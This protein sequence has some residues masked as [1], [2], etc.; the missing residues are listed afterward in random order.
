MSI[1]KWIQFVKN[2]AVPLLILALALGLFSYF[3]STK[4]LQPPLEV[5]AKVWPVK[6]ETVRLQTLS[7]V[8]TLFGTIQSNALVSAAAPLTGQIAQVWLQEGEEFT[9]GQSLVDMA[10]SDLQLPYLIAKADMEDTQAQLAIEK[11]A[12]QANQQKLL[13]EEKV[14]ALKKTDAER[15]AQL[16]KKN[17]ASQAAVDQSKETLVR[18][19]YAVVGA[20]LAVQQHEVTAQQ[21]TA[22]LAKAKANYEQA[23]INISRGHL[24]AP[25]AG[26]VAQLKVSQG[27]RVALGGALMQFY[28]FDS[29]ELK[30]KLPLDVMP[31]V[32]QSL[33]KGQTMRALYQLNG[34]TFELPF[35]RLAG[36]ASTSGVDAFFK[37]PNALKIARPGDLWQVSFELPPLENVFAMAYSAIYGSDS[38]YIVKEGV[39]QLETVKN[40]GETR[41]DGV[42]YALLRADIHKIPDGT[43]VV[44]THLP[45][46]ISG[47][48]VLV[49]E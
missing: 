2:A 47:L 18:Q 21:L 13:N 7:P 28:A 15:N 31:L 26:R 16:Y 19:E 46:A 42:S 8:Q 22:R 45:N 30:A 24:V 6:A 1:A 39:M 27:D 34:E 4:N 5:K 23:K 20:S 36:E 43:S 49:V 37:V 33:Q 25:Y 14:L 10:D 38:L 35:V 32:Y 12:Y 11:L 17:L 3:K 29:L 48:N 9:S 41:I 40:L 44:V